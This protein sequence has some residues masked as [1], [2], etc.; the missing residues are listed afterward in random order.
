MF[1]RAFR[2]SREAASGDNFTNELHLLQLVRHDVRRGWPTLALAESMAI[3][4]WNHQ[5]RNV[6]AQGKCTPDLHSIRSILEIHADTKLKVTTLGIRRFRTRSAMV[7]CR[8]SWCSTTLICISWKLDENS[9]RRGSG[10][11]QGPGPFQR[12]SPEY[13]HSVRRLKRYPWEKIETRNFSHES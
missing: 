5:R 9:G 8:C 7:R 3:F 6:C 11:G 10:R 2:C 1:T 13:K 4:L 12:R